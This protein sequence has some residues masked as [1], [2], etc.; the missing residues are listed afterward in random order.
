MTCMKYL[1]IRS[2]VA[3]MLLL[4][5]SHAVEAGEEKEP[6]VVRIDV[7]GCVT[8]T[9]AQVRYKMGTRAGKRLNRKTLDEDHQRL[10]KMGIFDD[11]QIKEEAV[12]KGIKIVVLL[13]E[14]TVIRR[15]VYRGNSQVKSEKLTSLIQ[16]KV[17]D[18]YDAGQANSDR[19]AIAEWYQEEFY[20]F[21]EVKVETEPFEDGI[22]VIFDITEG[23]RLYVQKIVFR[24][25]KALKRK[26]LLK[27]MET[28]P[29]TFF[30]RGRY[31]R[32]TFERDLERL[33]MLYRSKG[34]LDVQIIER[35]F[36]LT[37]NTPKSKWQRRDA[38]IHIDIDE[39]Q[40]YKVGRIDF[41]GNKLVPAEKLRAVLKTT[42][43]EVFNP[44]VIHE[45]ANRI[46]D[47]YGAYPSSRYFTKV[48][49]ERVLTEDGAVMDVLFK[50][51]E[52]EEVIAEGIRIKG[53]EKTKEFVVLREIEQLPGEKI[54]S[55]KINDSRRNL[56]NLG[57]FKEP[58]ELEIRPGS[59]PGRAIIVTDLEEQPT[60]KLQ[61]GA[62][63]STKDSVSGS[64]ELS[65]SNFSWRDYPKSWK[66]FFTGTAFKGAGQRASL[67]LTKGSTSSA[68]RFD[69]AE[70]WFFGRKLHFGSGVSY[71]SH[72]WNRYDEERT[73][74]YLSFGKNLFGN[75]RLYGSIKYK[76]ERVTLTDFDSDISQ[77]LKNEEGTN[78]I[79][80]YVLDLVYDT[81]NSRFD[82]SK[83]IMLRGSQELAGMVA[84]GSR[85][86]WRSFVEGRLYHPIWT[87]KQNRPWYIALRAELGMAE[88][89][90]DDEHV[91]IFEKMYAGGIGSVRG[92]RNRT[93]SPKD[94]HGDEIGGELRNTYSAEF[95]VP[96]YERILKVS[97]YYDLGAVYAQLDEANSSDWRSSAGIGVH[98]RTPLGPMPI[99]LYWNFPLDD[100]DGDDTQSFQFTFGAFF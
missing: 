88:A 100:V 79:N 16:S 22:R 46:R 15:I 55:A 77:A 84:G 13:R 19:R 87:D 94:N 60:G 67:K 34:Y 74:G 29:S 23:G 82:P 18:R 37:T 75:R 91:P 5:V 80:R 65:Q 21:A 28:R 66:D 24:G 51:A 47:I 96:V 99:R 39:G 31:D 71:T 20:Y 43:G 57:Y 38:Y 72:E 45:D 56:H 33:G 81:T 11:V 9:P 48:L 59:G 61:L 7:V 98:V 62:G 70:P 92:F 50:I 8:T 93:I 30:T 6:M 2:L 52:G 14:K 32:R 41:E 86:F 53:L 36:Q 3:A 12:E 54:D 10:F 42:P 64:I 58:F 49:G 40:M 44:A 90:G 97:G 17:G 83:G 95:F 63:I 69:F 1:T 85:D 25:N 78:W 27:F 73:G 68:F 76:A 26:E 35:P 89:Y 4:L